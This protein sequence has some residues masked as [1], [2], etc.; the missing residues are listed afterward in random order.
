MTGDQIIDQL[1]WSTQKTQ[2]FWDKA[3]NWL[4]IQIILLILFVKFF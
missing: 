4:M 3:S 2:M 1:N